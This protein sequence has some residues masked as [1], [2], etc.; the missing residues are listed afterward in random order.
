MCSQEGDRI[1][2]AA[3]KEDRRLQISRKDKAD[4][5]VVKAWAKKSNTFDENENA[6]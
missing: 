1:E 6:K 5:A 4:K 3:A 2:F